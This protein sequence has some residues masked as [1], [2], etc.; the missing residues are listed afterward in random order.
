VP[1]DLLVGLMSGTS[2]DAVD[3][4]LVRIGSDDFELLACYEHP[5]PSSLRERI[6]TLSHPG[7]Q[8][9]HGL[10]ELDR[11]LGEHF[12]EAVRT[13]LSQSSTSADR[14][15][16]IGSHGQTVRHHPPSVSLPGE[17]AYTLQIGDPNTIAESTGI[18]TVADFRRRDLAAG[19]EGAPLIPAFH[20]F[21][22][23]N[24]DKRRAVVNIGG[25]ANASLLLGGDVSGVDT[26]PGNTLLDHWILRHRGEHYDPLGAW[27]AEG[28]V[29][30]SLLAALSAH[31]Y[32]ALAPPKSTGKEAFNLDW[33]D[34]VLE[35]RPAVSPQDVQAT[36]AEF[37]AVSIAESLAEF[38]LDDVYVCGGG[39]SNTDLMRR[40]YQRLSP[41]YL[42]TTT[43]LG[44]DPA[45]VEASAF[46]W[47]AWRTL[48]G[49]PGNVAAVT[50]ASGPRVLGAIYPGATAGNQS[51]RV[52]R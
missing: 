49:L 7:E 35:S 30:S 52:V 51:D 17:R 19:G 28:E 1:D 16:A 27:S 20:D 31:P 40:L 13:L 23:A 32:L 15:R 42:G 4:V 33:L 3:A 38:S 18:T 14:V 8:E 21:L 24:A 2:M 50:G 26:G 22:F 29:N 39:A 25:I 9:I 44:C 37:T 6:H 11:E 12:A 34:E 46:A 43:E 36:L 47:L 41:V 45:W 5:M 48:N 10:G